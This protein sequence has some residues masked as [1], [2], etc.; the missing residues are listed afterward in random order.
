MTASPQELD[1]AMR[2]GGSLGRVMGPVF[3][4]P[5]NAFHWK[6]NDPLVLAKE[7]RIAI[8]SLS[9]YFNCGRDDDFQFEVGAEA[10]HRELDSEGIQHEYHL[11]PGDHSASYFLAHLGEVM[12]FHSRRFEKKR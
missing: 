5:I 4:N 11:Y 9:I 8:S 1:V 3:G 10:L 12:Q 6:E 7:N 2:S